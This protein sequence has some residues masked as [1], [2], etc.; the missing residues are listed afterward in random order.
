MRGRRLASEPA[1]GVADTRAQSIWRN[2]D[3]LLLW[4]AQAISQ[5][6]QQCI[7][8]GIV[9]L[10]Q[11]LSNSSTQLSLAVLTFILPSVLFSVLAGVYVDRWNK[12]NVLVWTNVLRGFIALSYVAVAQL[13]GVSVALVLALNTVFATIGQLFNP[14]EAALIPTLVGRKRLIEANGLFHL[15]FTA[16]QLVGLVLLGPLLVKLIG[17][18]PL[19]L[20]MGAAIMLCAGLVWPLPGGGTRLVPNARRSGRAA[21]ASVMTDVRVVWS[22]VVGDRL[23]ALAMLQ[24]TVGT[25]L[26]LI[27]AS[28]LPGY[29][30]RLLRVRA[31]DAVLVMAPAGIGLVI[32]TTMLNRWGGDWDK[33]YLPRVG[34]AVVSAGLVLLGALTWLLEW[35][36]EGAPPLLEMP[37][38]GQGSAMVPVAMLIAAAAGLAFVTIMVPTQAFIQ[39]QTPEE[40]RGRAFAVMFMLSSLASIAPLLLLGGLADVVGVDKAWMV[41]GLLIGV[42]AMVSAQVAPGTPPWRVQHGAAP[43]AE[44]SS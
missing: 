19:F 17:L 8:F 30:E 7:H 10:V 40:L 39:E 27:M 9:V 6:A 35:S 32:G 36:T 15:T 37:V 16:S 4:L 13:D 33:A 34:L 26:G 1:V 42:V 21:L 14:A 43:L 31:E 12:R 5:T 18:G 28:L 38:L 24:W 29:A 11:R 44:T 22:F 2:R 23:V 20:T 41:V 25:I 3:F